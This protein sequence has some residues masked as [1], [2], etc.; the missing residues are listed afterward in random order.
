MTRSLNLLDPALC[1]DPYPI[2]AELREA[3]PLAPVEPLGA[4]IAT[5]YD[6]VVEVLKD[7]ATYSSRAMQAAM[8]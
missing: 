7:S 3:T 1:V 8:P 4:W 5:R 2:Y 6:E